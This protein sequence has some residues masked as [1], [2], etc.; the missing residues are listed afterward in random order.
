MV[1][2]I[3]MSEWPRIDEETRRKISLNFQMTMMHQQTWQQG[4]ENE[5]R[6]REEAREQAIKKLIGG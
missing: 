4:M 3:P 1:D 6:I 5:S 2:V